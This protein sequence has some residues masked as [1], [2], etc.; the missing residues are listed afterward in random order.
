MS[1]K[2][3]SIIS[4]MNVGGPAVLVAELASKLNKGEFEHTLMAGRCEPNEKDYLNVRQLDGRVIYI[5]RMS[6]SIFLWNEL[7]AFFSLMRSLHAEKPDLIHTHMS[8]AGVLGR[9]AARIVAP[10]AKLVHTYHGHLLYGYF[11][12][13]KTRI[14]IWVERIL[15]R[16]T[17]QLIAITEN[18]K[19]D[20]ISVGIGKSEKWMVIRVGVE[21]EPRFEKTE[22]RGA[23]GIDEQLFC[24]IWIGRFADV[25]N[26]ML[27]LKSFN[28]FD[29]RDN[30]VLIM[31]GDG[32]LRQECERYSRSNCLN[33][34]FPGWA[35][36]VYKYLPAADLFLLTSKNEGMGM[37]I[38]EAATQAIPAL[39]TKVGGV[40]E[41]IEDEITGFFAEANAEQFA[42]RLQQIYIN[43]DNRKLVGQR[44]LALVSNEFSIQIFVQN[45]VALYRL[46]LVPEKS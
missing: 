29:A 39:S 19:D 22:T 14:V 27:A 38:L 7:V 12:K 17:D 32:D 44:A 31:V 42:N 8:K 23:L 6:R 13:W 9:L 26:P 37:V 5:D 4:R 1:K 11:P 20:L 45:H 24:L 41:F 25:K 36:D 2:V 30:S 40:S 33:V 28:N 43:A 46:L 35:D 15:A 10:Q 18:V 21:I 3:V 16:M 34:I